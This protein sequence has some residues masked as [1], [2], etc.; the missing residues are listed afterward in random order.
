M[1]I[2]LSVKDRV[3]LP[4]IFAANKDS[5]T[6]ACVQRSIRQLVAIDKQEAKEI[7]LKLVANGYA[8]DARKGL[9]KDFEF[10]STQMNYL[11][12]SIYNLSKAG[13][14]TQD[15]LPLCERITGNI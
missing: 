3:L 8:W 2:V 7:S 1:N 6:E 10:D 4:G 14:V 13:A 9:D 5:I 15:L 11:R 12:E